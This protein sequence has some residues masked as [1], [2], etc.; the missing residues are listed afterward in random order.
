MKK[1]FTLAEVLITLAIIGVVAAITIPSVITNTQQQEFKTGL[2]KAISVINSSITLNIAEEGES[3]ADN[4]DLFRYLQQ[5]MSVIASTDNIDHKYKNPT[6]WNNG[7]YS[8]A[9]FYTTDGMRFEFYKADHFDDHFPLYESTNL[10]AP[11]GVDDFGTACLGN[12]AP[13][14]RPD[15]PGFDRAWEGCGGC[16]SLGLVQEPD[17]MK[18]PCIITVDVNGDRK[19]N[20]ANANC[21]KRSCA[22]PYEYSLPDGKKLKDIFSIMITESKAIPYGTAAQRAMYKAR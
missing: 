13:E 1:A 2:K 20:P 6:Q 22:K 21:K 18:R 15:D 19:P 16:G 8:N 5:H 4:G 10:T 3:P 17:V 11:D 9:A 14:F 12:T 7:S